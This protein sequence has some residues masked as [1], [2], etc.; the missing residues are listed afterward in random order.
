[1]VKPCK[2]TLVSED[3]KSSV[4]S[5]VVF[6]DEKDIGTFDPDHIDRAEQLEF[7]FNFRGWYS[8]E[9][10]EIS[11]A[12]CALVLKL[13]HISVS[14]AITIFYSRISVDELINL[15]TMLAGN[16]NIKSLTLTKTRI[17]DAFLQTIGYYISLTNLRELCLNECFLSYSCCCSIIEQLCKVKS[18]IR[19]LNFDGNN[20]NYWGNE[21]SELLSRL[22]KTHAIEELSFV[23][24]NLRSIRFLDSNEYKSLKNVDVSGNQL[25]PKDTLI[26]DD[27][28]K[29]TKIRS[30]TLPY[31]N[32]SNCSNEQIKYHFAIANSISR[33]THLETFIS[34]NSNYCNREELIWE[35]PPLDNED[36]EFQKNKAEFQKRFKINTTS[37]ICLNLF[38]IAAFFDVKTTCRY[39]FL[40]FYEEIKGAV[41]YNQIVQT[42][43]HNKKKLVIN[44]SM[45]TFLLCIKQLNIVLCE[46]LSIYIYDF[47]L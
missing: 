40:C 36:A 24:C 27:L 44:Q 20:L 5:S 43:K 30:I 28:L 29:S 46:D 42:I 13:A 8:R 45:I 41:F 23:R 32:N 2:Y 35:I 10:T 38:C 3:N 19:A 21:L 17:S 7:N 11:E 25:Y 15:F 22:L 14:V 33:I 31:E 6:S 4:D 37:L 16:P 26:L 18:S 12:F 47:L 34:S 9:P 1:M 39:E